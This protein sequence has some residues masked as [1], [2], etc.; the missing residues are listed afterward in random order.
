MSYICIQTHQNFVFVFLFFF[1]GDVCK[2]IVFYI[3]LYPMF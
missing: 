3:E 1:V 2:G